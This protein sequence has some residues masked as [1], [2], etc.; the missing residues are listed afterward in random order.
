MNQLRN[1]CAGLLLLLALSVPAFAG[2]ILT[3]PGAAGPTEVPG[4]ADGTA[5]SPGVAGDMHTPSAAGE[6]QFPGVAESPGFAG[7]M[8]TPSI[9]LAIGLLF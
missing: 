2:E 8:D 1:L 3:P 6:T 9:Y 5:E 7:I 4:R